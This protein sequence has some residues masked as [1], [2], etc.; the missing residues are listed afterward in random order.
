MPA[1]KKKT[2]VKPSAA[3]P[4]VKAPAKKTAAPKKVA[5]AAPVKAKAEKPKKKP[6]AKAAPAKAAKI[7][8]PA[9]K[10]P[11]QK[12]AAKPVAKAAAKPAAKKAPVKKAA[13]PKA[14]RPPVSKAPKTPADPTR[15]LSVDLARLASDL[16]CTDV[17]IQDVTGLSTLTRFMILAT[18]VS[19]R[20]L[21]AVAQNMEELG[22]ARNHPVYKTDADT[23]TTWV[24]LDLVDI[25]VHLFEP[26]AR[27]HYDL[28]TQF[29]DAK[30]VKWMR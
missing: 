29:P 18:G 5:K 25:M 23:N 14:A 8:K 30:P 3:K 28:E 7:V 15:E 21:K 19:N 10:K 27:S 16:H 11:V 22:A 17:M 12:A 13:A 26:A 9:A 2:A 6:V 4:A 24:V 20:Q 1:P